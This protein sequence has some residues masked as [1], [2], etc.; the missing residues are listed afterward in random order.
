[1]F[2]ENWKKKKKADSTDQAEIIMV[3]SLAAGK[4]CKALL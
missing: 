4:A 1:M 3:E 2:D